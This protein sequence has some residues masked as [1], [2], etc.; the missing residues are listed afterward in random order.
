MGTSTN[1]ILAYG[2]DLGGDESEWKVEQAGEYGSLPRLDWFD[3]DG[4]DGFVTAVEEWLLAAAGFSETDWR[5]DGYF[6]RKREA[7]ATVGVKFASYCS[8]DYPMWIIAAKVITVHRGDV[9]TLDLDAL[10]REPAEHCWDEKLD[11]AMRTL[12]LTPTQDRPKWL[13]CSYWS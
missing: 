10:A 7:E 6:D 13:L 4:D 12:G 11:A 5:A 1:A 3:P 9:K 8:G 2:Y